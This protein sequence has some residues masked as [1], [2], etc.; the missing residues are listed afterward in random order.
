MDQG[1]I[2]EL[3]EKYRKERKGKKGVKSKSKSNFSAHVCRTFKGLVPQTSDGGRCR[4]GTGSQQNTVVFVTV[5]VGNYDPP[6][7]VSIAL[8]SGWI[9]VL[10]F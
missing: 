6:R 8:S 4:H 1:L 7:L 10:S 2:A 9:W 5:M 3:K